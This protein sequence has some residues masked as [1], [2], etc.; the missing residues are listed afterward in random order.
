MSRDI[1]ISFHNDFYL[2][3]SN[4]VKII[5]LKPSVS[6]RISKNT[7]K[8]LTEKPFNL[9]EKVSAPKSAKFFCK[10]LGTDN[11]L[12]YCANPTSEV[13]AHPTAKQHSLMVHTPPK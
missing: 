9:V 12:N 11:N 3:K 6:C 10:A 1:I 5:K 4:N 7:R 8:Q 13:N 2:I